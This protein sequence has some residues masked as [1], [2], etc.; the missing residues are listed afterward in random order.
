MLGRSRGDNHAID[1]CPTATQAVAMPA[2]SDTNGSSAETRKRLIAVAAKHFADHGFAAASQRAIQREAGVN[3][4][5]SHYH[6]GSK[7]AM[8]QAVIDAFVHDVQA[9]RLRRL[10]EVPANLSGHARLKRLLVD[11]YAPG[12]AVA[13]TPSGFHYARILARTQ[14]ERDSNTRRIFN[15]IVGPIRER[16]VDSIHATLQQISRADAYELLATGVTLMAITAIGPRYDNLLVEGGPEREADRV[17]TIVAAGY[18]A[19]LGLDGH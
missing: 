13:L 5:S 6:F 17:A 3:P 16:Y 18:Q 11:Y 9:E 10:E 14:G 4:A 7:G 15:E 2:G 19:M 8:F 12:F 1:R